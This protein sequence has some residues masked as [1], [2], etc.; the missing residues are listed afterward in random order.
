MQYININIGGAKTDNKGQR[1]I[2]LRRQRA[3]R[4]APFENSYIKKT[5]DI[6]LLGPPQCG[7]SNGINQLIS[8][9]DVLWPRWPTLNCHATDPIS[10]WTTQPAFTQHLKGQGLN[11]QKMG[12]EERI[13]ALLAWARQH[14][15][16]LIIDDAHALSARKLELMVRL[17]QNAR[18][19]V[20]G[21]LS[22]QALHPS[23]RTC[24][25]RRAPQVLIFSS[26][27]PYDATVILV[28]LML[29]MALAAGWYELAAALTT[30]RALG[31]GPLASRQR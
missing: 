24:L 21:A 11:P 23:L 16:V 17:A 4:S 29:L 6:W 14:P 19:V 27:T 28:C 9:S 31:H 13:D 1:W 22:E 15:I 5:Q 26:E 7:K 30:A 2:M 10:R 18:L 25:Q 12:A 20:M 3:F 8:K